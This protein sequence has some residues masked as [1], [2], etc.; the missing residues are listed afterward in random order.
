MPDCA[1]VMI[2][3]DDD[4]ICML[5]ENALSDGYR[6]VTVGSGAEC[7]A[8]CARQRPDII[9][10]DVEMPEMDG[11][12]TCR[13][14]KDDN[15]HAAPVIFISSHDRL[16]DRLRGYDAGGDDYLLKPVDPEELVTKV[17]LRL[18]AVADQA[19]LKQMVDY[20]SSTAMTALSSMGEMGV[21]LQAL[22]RFNGC[23]GLDELAEAVVQALAEYSLHGVVRLRAPHATTIRSTHGEASPIELSII[24]QVASMGRIV[25]YRSRLSVSYD[26]VALVVNN[27]PPTDD[28]R[29]G[30]LRDHLAVLA[31]GAE[32]RTLAIHRDA[33]IERVVL[34]AGRT[35][36]RIDESQREVQVAS[37]LALHDMSTQLERAYVSAAL[38]E[39]QENYM[40]GIVGAGLERVRQALL[41]ETDVQRQLTA[42]IDE[43]KTVTAR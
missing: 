7:L 18:K 30:R 39:S 40:A 25:E 23:A 13:R 4:L 22:Q 10:L 19:Q 35:L 33:V 26:H 34:Q 2:V 20:A 17:G 12:E 27:M 3:D 16:E 38:S 6:V 11:Y 1:T 21:L 15:D 24:D 37:S 36:D 43:L 41:A 5:L 32:L 42:V 28:D 9:L 14:I 31:E 8:A 29:R